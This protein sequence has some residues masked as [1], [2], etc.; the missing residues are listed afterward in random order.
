MSGTNPERATPRGILAA[1]R[2]TPGR[3]AAE[4]LKYLGR[5]ELFFAAAGTTLILVLH[6]LAFEAGPSLWRDEVAAV[7]LAQASWNNFWLWREFDS[8]FLAW[9]AI[10]RGWM[11]FVGSSDASLRILGLG[12]GFLSLGA[13]WWTARQFG[14]TAPLLLLSLFAFNSTLIYWGDTLRGYGL[15]A[16]LVLVSFALYWRYLQRP[17]LRDWFTL[18]ACGLLM[19]HLV[20]YSTIFLGAMSAAALAVTIR[21]RDW[22]RTRALLLLGI[23]WGCSLFPYLTAIQHVTQW[24]VTVQREISWRDLPQFFRDAAFY[25]TSVADVAWLVTFVALPLLL[26]PRI[27]GLRRKDI[28][29]TTAGRD[30]LPPAL[31]VEGTARTGDLELFFLISSVLGIAGFVGVIFWQSYVPRP[32]HFIL[33]IA[34]TSLAAEVA[35]QQWVAGRE[36]LIRLRLYAVVAFWLALFAGPDTWLWMLVIGTLTMIAE[37]GLSLHK[38]SPR[39]GATLFQGGVLILLALVWPPAVETYRTRRT[40]LDLVAGQLD[41]AAEPGDVIIVNPCWLGLTFQRY[42]HGPAT[43]MTLP[44][45]GPFRVHR[46]DLLIAKMRS[47][48]PLADLHS[49]ISTTLR[50]QHKVYWV[51]HLIADPA[52]TAPGEFIPPPPQKFRDKDYSYYWTRLMY[53]YLRD[54]ASRVEEQAVAAPTRVNPFELSRLFVFEGWKDSTLPSPSATP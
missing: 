46:Y 1:P 21:R 3:E 27:G 11:A 25:R 13:C 5:S 32:W 4:R 7:N 37:A 2:E 35:V 12:I 10:L 19:L 23:F 29:E 24:R 8:S 39:R 43:V 45:L 42:Y 49:A 41:S 18:L 52:G 20:Y 50:Q 51:G 53:H 6:F 15:A 44:H 30:S 26:L 47:P 33:L 16:T 34:A 54:H 36:S 48:E 31:P 9:F 40:N 28:T 38:E 22:P 17:R 14:C